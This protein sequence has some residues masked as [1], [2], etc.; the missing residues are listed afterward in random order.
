MR[1][2]TLVIA[3]TT[4]L[5]SSG[6]A[7]AQVKGPD[8]G[9]EGVGQ[10]DNPL[11]DPLPG[12]T[13]S[14]QGGTNCSAAIADGG[15]ANGTPGATTTSTFS[16][17]GCGT[18]LDV[19]IGLDVSHTWVGDLIFTVRSPNNTPV[20]I[21]D[22][23]GVP[24]TA[25]GCSGNN[26]FATLDD[27]QGTAPV[28][29]TCFVDPA[30]A[31]VLIPNNPLSA[32]DGLSADGTWTLEATDNAAGDTGSLNDWSVD[33]YTETCGQPDGTIPIARFPVT[34][35]FDDDNPAGVDVTISCN[36]GLPLEQT[37][38]ITEAGPGVTFVVTDF[39]NGAMDC[40]ITETGGVDGYDVEYAYSATTSADEYSFSNVFWETSNACAITN[41]LLPVDVL[42][43]KWWMDENPQFNNPLFA[44]ASYDCVNEQFGIQAF[45]SL[46][47][48]GDGDVN[49]FQVFPDW[50]GT[51]SCTVEETFVDSGVEFDD[52]E[53]AGLTV[54]PGVGA[55]CN[56]YN[57]R[58]YEGI[59]T[60]SQ[61]GL[62]L[63]AL[64]MLGM[65]FVAFRRF[66]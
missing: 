15:P 26:I 8:T 42:V 56:I 5:L 28:E 66:V 27:D 16:I 13:C 11:G 63:L 37:Q 31:G 2:K 7:F 64:L 3:V 51:T 6:V 18:I 22:R 29:D 36:T 39:E 38:T 32:L 61:Y 10:S 30:I 9:I 33:V 21:Y 60:L 43:T 65:G 12:F 54:L 24:N 53:C 55:S 14:G 46:D 34:K 23:P 25:F 48:F 45:G 49:G 17:D 47:F 62:G 58:L 57:T 1:T 52:S 41:S 50:D 35:D 44:E 20:T 4:A 59:P 19:E 40:T